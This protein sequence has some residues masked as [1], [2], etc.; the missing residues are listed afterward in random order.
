MSW[1]GPLASSTNLMVN[2]FPE[3]E[4]SISVVGFLAERCVRLS[5]C[6]ST[7]ITSCRLPHTCM[8][9]GKKALVL[10]LTAPLGIDQEQEMGPLISIGERPRTAVGSVALGRGVCGRVGG[11]LITGSVGKSMRK[12]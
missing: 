1:M 4:M 12:G 8:D 9:A 2:V 11:I 7:E 3:K 10:N 5:T 6:S